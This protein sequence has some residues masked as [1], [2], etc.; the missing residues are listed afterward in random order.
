MAKVGII[1]VSYRTDPEP[2]FASIAASRHQVRW[3]IFVHGQ[4]KFLRAKLDAF[5]ANSDSRYFPYGINRGLARSWNDGVIASF[6]D[7][8]EVTIVL[9]DDLFFYEGGFDE[10]VDFILSEA[11]RVPDYGLVMLYGMEPRE[12]NYSG[13]G[14][15]KDLRRILTLG[16]CFAL[17]RG[18]VDKVGYFDENFWPAYY[19][20]FDYHYRLGLAKVPILYDQRALLEHQRS[21]TR[22]HDRLVSLLH[23]E[24]MQ[25]CKEYYIRKWGGHNDQEMY[26]H[27]FNDPMLSALIT[28][29][30]RAMPYDQKYGRTDLPSASL[31]FLMQNFTEELLGIIDRHAAAPRRCLLWSGD[32]G[33]AAM[34]EY[35]RA[36]GTDFFLLIDDDGARLQRSAR[37]IPKYE[38]L[39]LRH[40]DAKDRPET[41]SATFDSA[42]LTYPLSL[43][44]PFDVI[45]VAGKW[46]IE[47]ALL[48]AGALAQEG[49]VV[50]DSSAGERRRALR[51]FLSTRGSDA[52]SPVGPLL[53]EWHQSHE[54]ILRGL[55]DV[56]E[57]AGQFLVL[58][59]KAPLPIAAAVVA[60]GVAAA[61]TGDTG[62]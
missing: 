34:I 60:A 15:A 19:E 54:R 24:R 45:V 61:G 47:C 17:G 35:A 55:Y 62:P 6:N 59:L 18:A 31:G 4:D 50:F 41:A 51:Q 43:G 11:R 48:A 14:D 46:R 25:R 33:A 3:Y 20:D 28:Q 32:E 12:L 21:A 7:E 26:V 9:N 2:L 22:R 38:F 30:Q 56:V 10:F 44:V 13:A 5:V 53:D 39:H 49:L 29:A 1:V 42:Y 40:F 8:N 57:Q 23:P 37:E 58:R 36:H 52:Q 16:A 27:P